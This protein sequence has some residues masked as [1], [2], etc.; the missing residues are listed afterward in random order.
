M[1]TD[2]IPSKNRFLTARPVPIT[3]TKLNWSAMRL[4]KEDNSSRSGHATNRC[5]K[6]GS[7]YVGLLDGAILHHF[8][9]YPLLR[10]CPLY[11]IFM[12]PYSSGF[13]NGSAEFRKESI[14]VITQMQNCKIQ[15]LWSNRGPN[16]SRSLSKWSDWNSLVDGAAP[17]IVC[18]TM[19]MIILYDFLDSALAARKHI[20]HN[21]SS[22]RVC[23]GHFQTLSE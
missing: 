17:A 16:L 6:K 15:M 1:L 4:I 20:Q 2:E 13:F 21:V 19:E 8:A 10:Q 18:G 23:I 12:I 22:Q 14:G 3:A 7:Q 9:R 11:L 5:P